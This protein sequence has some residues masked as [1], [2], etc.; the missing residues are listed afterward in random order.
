MET[1][2]L[3]RE[4]SL[5]LTTDKAS[6]SLSADKTTTL[7]LTIDLITYFTPP[8]FT[9]VDWEDDTSKVWEDGVEVSWQ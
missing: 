4:T 5:S 1:I 2:S 3:N 9:L 6:L 8:A 7:T